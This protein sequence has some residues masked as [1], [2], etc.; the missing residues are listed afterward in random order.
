[1]EGQI[2]DEAQEEQVN[3]EIEYDVE[4][5]LGVRLVNRTLKYKVKWINCDEDPEEYRASDLKNAPKLLQAFHTEYPKAP[6]PPKNLQYWLD[7]AGSDLFAE[8]RNDDDQPKDL[9]TAK[10]VEANT[11]RKK[12][13][14]R[15]EV[16]EESRR[17]ERLRRGLI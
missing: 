15:F 1:L 5:I 11:R 6:G 9:K 13:T 7:C 8:E 12:K 4:T 17:S 10:E 3:G 2:V 14:V 16:D